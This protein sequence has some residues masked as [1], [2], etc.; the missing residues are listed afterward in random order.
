MKARSRWAVASWL[1]GRRFEQI[2]EMVKVEGSRVLQ[3]QPSVMGTPA[4]AAGA[5]ARAGAA[6]VKTSEQATYQAG[7]ADF[8]TGQ[9]DI[10]GRK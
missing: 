3:S 4:W 6:S 2:L 1:N 8:V 10:S 5:A 7:D 9:E